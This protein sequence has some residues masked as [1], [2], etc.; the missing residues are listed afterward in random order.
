MN[1]R[2]GIWCAVSSKPQTDKISLQAQE[3]QGRAFAQAHGSVIAVYTVP[4][5]SR[6][7]VLWSEA[8]ARIPAYR[9][10]R[11][12]IQAGR[13]D[14]L[15]AYDVD[16]LGRDPAL[17]QQVISLV[18]NSGAEVYLATAP[19]VVG[20]KTTGSRYISA[21]QSVRAKEET[22]R[23]IYHWQLGMGD[24]TRQGLHPNRWPHG[25]RAT[26]DPHTGKVTGAELTEGAEAVREITRLFLAGHS[27]PAIVR[28]M[29]ATGHR[30]PKGTRWIYDTIRRIT[31]DDTYAG[32]VSWR[33]ILAAEPSPHYP[34]LWDPVTHRAIIRER[35]RRRR[36]YNRR[37]GS[38]LSGVAFCGLCGSRMTRTYS[39][40][41][42]YLR[43]GRYARQS[44]TGI[45][46]Q[47]NYIKEA[48]AIA[49]VARFLE[50]ELIPQAIE[51]ILTQDDPG[52][53]L[54]A[55]LATL[56]DRI[57]TLGANRR[58]IALDRAAG[59]MEPG[60]YQETDRELA[61]QIDRAQAQAD[62]IQ[63]E[64]E[65]I[66]DPAGRRALLGDLA[67]HFADHLQAK[68]PAEVAT[69]LQNAGLG[70]VIVGG[71]VIA[72]GFVGD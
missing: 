15:W 50:Q 12:D 10:L 42:N 72:V 11:A 59:I 45:R 6:D 61:G 4:G 23:R 25:Y 33:D 37:G 2:I 38:P 34:A 41:A 22:Q 28:A 53:A 16:R 55:D 64:L 40:H 49:A 20:Q 66:P 67:A 8:E 46:C 57:A 71:E 31:L 60:I 24:R 3:A 43:C 44:R 29:N 56:Q 62:A 69:M 18:E 19:H 7:L 27:Y 13:L 52:S 30:P 35:A 47:P 26:R 63:A 9:A 51:D 5:I 1:L 36:A 54:R 14:L 32:F 17:S 21:I 68:A 65:A 70:L 48:T 39:S 58:R